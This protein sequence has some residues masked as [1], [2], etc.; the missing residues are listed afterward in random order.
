MT[1]YLEKARSACEIDRR[2]FVQGSLAATAA[3]AATSALSGCSPKVE[4]AKET[5]SQPSERNL[6]EGEW[7]SAPCWHN[8]GGRCFNKVLVKDGVIVRQKTDDVHEDTWEYLQQRGCLRGRSQQQQVFSAQRIKYPMKRKNWEPNGGGKRELRGVDEWERI[9]WDEAL[10]LVASEIKRMYADFGPRSVYMNSYGTGPLGGILNLMGGHISSQ[11]T[12]SFGSWYAGPLMLGTTY[13]TYEPDL[14]STNDRFDVLNAETVVLYGCNPVWASPGNPSYVF[15]NAKK[16]GTQF[17]YVGPSYN[18]SAQLLDARWIRVRP[19]TD[20]A[21]LLAVAYTM[22][23]EDSESNPLIDWDFLNRCTVGFDSDHM[24]AD[25]KVDENFRSYVLGEYDGIPKTPEWAHEM[26]GTPVEDIQWYAREMSC[27]KKVMILHSYAAARC[28]GAEDLP[29]LYL[30]V[31]AMGGHMGKSGHA[32]GSAYQYEAGNSGSYLVS[33]G[34]TSLQAMD[35]MMNPIDDLL[36]SAQINRAIVEGRYYYSG[37][38][39]G[40]KMATK[41]GEWREIDVRLIVN[42]GANFFQ[43]RVDVN[44]AVEAYRKVE[45]VITASYDFNPSAQYSDIVLPATT[46]W[47]VKCSLVDT[48]MATASMCHGREMLYFPNQVCEPLFEAKTDYELSLLLAEKLGLPKEK[49]FAGTPAQMFLVAIKGATVVGEDGVTPEPLVTIDDEGLAYYKERFGDAT[50]E[51][52]KGRITIKEFAERGGYQV[53]RKQGDNYGFIAYEAFRND[54]ENNPRESASG[55]LE[56]YCQAKAD[57]YNMV[58]YMDEEY[59]PYPTYHKPVDGYEASFSDWGSKAKGEYPFQMFTPHYLRR[60]H[61]VFENLPWVREAFVNPVFIN[62]SDAAEKGIS[63]GD[64][65]LVYNQ[66]GK[67]LRNATVLESIMPGCIALPHGGWPKIDPKTGID[68]GG[69]ENVLTGSVESPQP[70]LGSYN[71]VLVNYEKWTE[72]ALKPDS[73]TDPCNMPALD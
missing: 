28:N 8:C 72:E 43:S 59:K 29:Q 49:L 24:P 70:M 62:A 51:H 65:V 7:L 46:A 23:T 3:L 61:T 10:D 14:C 44:K 63:D 47:E 53:E 37:N 64:T 39:V 52:Q 32:C 36:P 41:P 19:G 60:A 31:G 57:S 5:A 20:T 48:V 26:C 38:I 17:V 71:T 55:K 4:P 58:G 18:V 73:E 11:A 27:Q 9:S 6:V 12:D 66:Y 15:M 67:V 2:K 25:A 33:W 45:T 42:H 54:P 56:I 69:N 13:H 68:H 34:A 16:G 22:L 30:T 50:C 21:F 1:G 35:S 40:P